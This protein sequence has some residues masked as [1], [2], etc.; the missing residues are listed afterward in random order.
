MPIRIEEDEQQQPQNPRNPGGGRSGGG[1]LLK[2]LPFVAMFLFKK[3]KLILP[4]LVIGGILYYMGALDGCMGEMPSADNGNVDNSAFTF[5][6]SLSE[7]QYDKAQQYAALA[8]TSKNQMPTKVSLKQY[9]PKRLNQGRQGSCVG[10]ASAYAARTIL[11]SRQTGQNPNQVAFSPSF[12]YNQIALENCQGAYVID[13]MK[14]MQQTGALTLTEFPYN[15]RTCGK[16]PNQYQVLDAK[17]FRING[18]NRLSQDYNRYA[19]DMRAIKE[20]LAQGAPVIIGMQV[21]G[22]FMQRMEGKKMWKPTSSD[23]RGQGFSG[24]AMCVIGYD[25]NYNGGAFQIMNSW[26]ERWGDE[27]ITWVAYPDFERFVKEAYGLHPMGSA[28]KINEDKMSIRFGLWDNASQSNIPVKK[29][30]GNLFTTQNPLKVGQK[31]KLEVTNSLACYV[32]VIGQETDGSSYT[33]FPYTQKHSPYCGIVGTRVFPKD[34]S[35]FPDDK[36]SKDYFTIIACKQAIDPTQLTQAIDAARG[37]NYTD[38]VN[39]AL[40]QYLITNGTFSS[41]GKVAQFQSD[42]LQGK[43][44]T[45][46]VFEV[47]K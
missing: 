26:G 29:V 23:Y 36:G 28:D 18:Y 4:A 44:A 9:A 8:T 17:N 34:H 6:A 38:K 10:W 46:V 47:R 31:F 5:G 21:G 2:I 39:N 43:I 16:N 25:D 37:S 33:L 15:E 40:S 1:G 11:H 20:N 3:P 7:E 12:L 32:Y 30:S 14:T 19:V 41:G 35:L 45:A 24:H 42:K 13:A 22:T 27:G